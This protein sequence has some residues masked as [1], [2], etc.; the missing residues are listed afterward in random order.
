[1]IIVSHRLSVVGDCDQI[2]V[3]EAGRIVV[4]GTHEQLLALRG[5]YYTMARHQLGLDRELAK[6][7]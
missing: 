7:A 5:H 6:A 4:Q 3:M 1:M 2:F